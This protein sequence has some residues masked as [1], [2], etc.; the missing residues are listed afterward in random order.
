[1]INPLYITLTHI[2]RDI[3]DIM[4][5]TGKPMNT[6]QI[7]GQL[8]TLGEDAS[9][10]DIHTKRAQLNARL[11]KMASRGLLSKTIIE[12]KPW[13]KDTVLFELTEVFQ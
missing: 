8:Y 13:R 2:D 5:A 10:W 6:S 7:M 3:V 11:N 12:D 1:M 4:R 9:S